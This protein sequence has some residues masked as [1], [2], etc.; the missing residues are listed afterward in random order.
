MKFRAHEI[1][2]I[3][4][5]PF[6]SLYFSEFRCAFNRLYT[7]VSDISSPFSYLFRRCFHRIEALGV[8]F[9]GWSFLFLCPFYEILE[10]HWEP[11]IYDFLNTVS[12][13]STV[14]E[15][16]LLANVYTK[17]SCTTSYGASVT[18]GNIEFHA[19]CFPRLYAKYRSTE[20]VGARL[21]EK[22]ST[23]PRVAW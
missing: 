12:G 17:A 11:A 2:L 10:C 14:T 15:L 16:V 3:A 22:N 18:R 8:S 4:F 23:H 1:E 9:D 20:S 5:L 13:L 6:V 21:S 19:A 7:V